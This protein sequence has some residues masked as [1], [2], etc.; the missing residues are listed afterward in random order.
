MFLLDVLPRRY[1]TF[2]NKLKSL[3]S[4]LQRVASSIALIGQ[5][6]FYGVIPT[7]AKVKGSF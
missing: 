5:S 6:L 2:F 1:T 7:F 3:T 4:K